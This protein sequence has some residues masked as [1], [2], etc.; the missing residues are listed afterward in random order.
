MSQTKNFRPPWWAALV[1]AGVGFLLML[2]GAVHYGYSKP[3]PVCSERA[4][5]DQTEPNLKGSL[6]VEQQGTNPQELAYE[7][8]SSEPP[9]P[10]YLNHNP[11]EWIAMLTATL[12]G[13]TWALAIFTAYLWWDTRLDGERQL[14]AAKLS[15][16]ATR[17]QLAE[18]AAT[19]QRESRP[20][21]FLSGLGVEW[22]HDNTTLDKI[23]SY[24]V[25]LEWR[26]TG[27]TPARRVKAWLNVKAFDAPGKTPES[28]A[29]ADIPGFI[30][31]AQS[32]G[33]LLGFS[34]RT[35]VDAKDVQQAFADGRSVFA[36]GWVEYDGFGGGGRHR[37]EICCELSPSG[38][39]TL[40]IPGPE[41]KLF[42][43][44]PLRDSFRTSFN[45]SDADCV[46][47]PKT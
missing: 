13:F 45:A 33:P 25:I 27:R 14:K 8:R 29:F 19:H 18:G 5:G 38:D 23:A 20:Y 34:S 9:E 41:G 28:D 42:M 24:R 3:N 32:V 47:K 11:E 40:L 4:D 21:V 7:A 39:P 26:N 46:H 17:R 37:T 22:L 6:I 44:N 31:E 36:W 30:Q 43:A 16:R 15:L 12:S 35:Q 10:C 2:G 1:I